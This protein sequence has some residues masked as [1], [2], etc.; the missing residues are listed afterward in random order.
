[1]TPTP[2]SPRARLSLLYAVVF[3]EMG[4]AMP[5]MPVW[6]DAQGLDARIIGLLLALPIAT[7]ILVTRP[8]MGLIDLGLGPQRLILMA[9]LCLA[10]TYAAM[11]ATAEIGWPLLAVAVVANAVAGAPLVPSI[12]F[13]TLSA[14]RRDPRLD[15]ARIRVAGS[16]AFLAANLAAGAMLVQLGGKVSVPVFLTAFACLATV[17][18]ATTRLGEA[19]PKAPTVSGPRPALPWV[20]RLSIA[21]AAAIQS[22][23]AAIYG[24]ASIHWTAHGFSG[25][26]V[27][28]LWATGVAAEI[29]LFAVVGRLPARWKSPFRLLALG[30]SAALLRAL[31]MTAFGAELLPVIALQCLHGLTFGATQ[32]G[33][34]AAVSRFAPEGARGRAQGTL[35][36]ASA[37]AAACATLASGLAYREGGP[38]AFALMAPAA[39]AGLAFVGAAVRQARAE[40]FGAQASE[41]L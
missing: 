24:F 10:L 31:G 18:A 4:I 17:V 25:A 22:T 34:M 39:L 41:R 19:V 2:P 33:A 8:L 35:S 3:V 16:V 26:T 6:L 9:S 5:F 30:G 21:A 40:P 27:G 1:M 11:P 37:L 23:H 14:V 12:D 20:L 38:L 13:L 7:R 29:L 28:A 32:L 36:S 15:Y